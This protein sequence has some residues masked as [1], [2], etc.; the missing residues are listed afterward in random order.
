MFHS[1]RRAK[2]AMLII[3]LLL[4][5]CYQVGNVQCS[6]IHENSKDLRSLLNFKQETSDP[7]GALRNW[8][9]DTHF[10]GWNGVNC[11]STP[12]FRVNGLILSGYGLAGPI[13]SSLGNLFHLEQLDLSQN[14]FD[15]PI[16][17]LNQFQHLNVL[18]LRNNLLHGVIPDAPTNCSNLTFLDSLKTC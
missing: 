4:L 1:K 15:G 18:S 9:L 11:S 17:L 5:L 12:P 8:T 14:H 2:F 13:S 16:L 7:N 6:T 10:C 3:L